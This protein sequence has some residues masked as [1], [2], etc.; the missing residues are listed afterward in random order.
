VNALADEKVGDYLNQHFVS[1]FQKVGTFRIVG[2]QKQGG[3][4]V[5]YLC[6]PDGAI[7]DAVAGPVDAA[8]LLREARW[9][10]ENRKTALLEA[11][12]NSQRFKQFFRQ[13]HA[14]QL[15]STAGFESVNWQRMAFNPPTD[16]DL[17]TLLDK[18]PTAHQ[19]SQQ[20]R[21]HLL[22]AVFPLVPIDRAYKAVYE[23]ILGERISTKPVAER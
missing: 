23:K 15:T 4:V 13:A 17:V 11:H 5:S 19:L 12:G 8:T 7:L 6:L 14:D 16:A 20:D 10:V 3:N 9:V 2:G 1:S 21:M 18:Y 22:L